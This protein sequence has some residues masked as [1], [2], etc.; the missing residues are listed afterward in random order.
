[1]QPENSSLPEDHFSID[2]QECPWINIALTG[3]EIETALNQLRKEKYYK[4]QE[5]E[6]YRKETRRI[7]FMRGQW[8]PTDMLRYIQALRVPKCGFS[9]NNGADGLPVF[10]L[11]SDNAT[12]FEVLCHYFTNSPIFESLRIRHDDGGMTNPNWRFNRGLLICGSVGVGKTKLMQLFSINKRRNYQVLSATAIADIYARRDDYG[13]EA[14]IRRFSAMHLNAP[15]KHEDN[16]WQDKIGLCID[17]LGTEEDK[18]NFGNKSNVIAE[19]IM[20]RYANNTLTHDMTHITTNLSLTGIKE[21]YGDR[22]LSRLLEMF[23]V[24]ELPGN[25]RR[26]A[27]NLPPS[28]ETPDSISIANT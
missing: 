23:N 13:G 18:S 27:A 24:I 4:E 25:D 26:K 8:E 16:L 1:M 5:R 15:M 28:I 14:C 2:R 10:R 17:D 19:I 12:I 3:E 11:D 9:L 21:R 7:E 6:A 22:F 20:G